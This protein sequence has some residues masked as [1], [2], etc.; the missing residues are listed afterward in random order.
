[1]IAYLLA[2]SPRRWW[3]VALLVLGAALTS[4]RDL[5]DGTAQPAAP[6]I[7]PA[8]VEPTADPLLQATSLPQHGDD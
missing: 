5:A 1:M 8:A 3:P 7:S 6:V 2:S 4:C